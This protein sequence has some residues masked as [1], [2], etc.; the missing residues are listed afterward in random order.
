MCANNSWLKTYTERD[1]DTKPPFRPRARAHTM[2]C[3]LPAVPVRS[4][5]E[6]QR[7]GSPLHDSRLHLLRPVLPQVFVPGAAQPDTPAL[8][9]APQA[10]RGGP[11]AQH[12]TGKSSYNWFKARSVC[13]VT[14]LLSGSWLPL[15][16]SGHGGG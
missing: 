6:L 13:P 12:S 11:R 1:T 2:G 14:L 4:E 9:P 15:F 8:S 10:I 5:P 7:S 16:L 3:R